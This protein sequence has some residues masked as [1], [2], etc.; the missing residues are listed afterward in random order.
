M[1]PI[2]EVKEAGG[3]SGTKDVAST[4]EQTV[5]VDGQ[6]RRKIRIAICRGDVARHARAQAI[7]GLAEA[8]IELASNRVLAGDYRERIIASLE[9]EIQRLKAERD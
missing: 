3:C 6:A 2:V 9:R 7:Q 1:V 4:T 5:I 8:R